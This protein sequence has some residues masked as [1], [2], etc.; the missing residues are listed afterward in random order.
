METFGNITLIHG[1]CMDYMREL[2]D[3]SID[4][5]ISDPPYGIDFCSPRTNNHD[6][7]ANDGFEE[8]QKALPLWLSEFKRVL[9][10]TGCCCCGGGG[11]KPVS[12]IFTIEIIKAGF[13]LVQTLIWDKQTIGLGWHYR[14]SY[15]TIIVFSKSKK[16]NWFDDSKKVSNIIRM[17][18]IIPQKGDHPTPKPIDLMRTLIRLHTAPGMTV[19]DPFLGGGTTALAA[20]IEHR[21]CIG[22]EL[23]HEY[24]EL[25]KQRLINHQ[26]QGKLF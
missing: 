15:E 16:Y 26:S 8:F 14:P 3:N 4:A 12:Q 11:N 13:H 17:N 21:K 2:P 7:I 22:I 1:D 24:Y 25:A 5:I 19:L 18:N 10:D 23:K 9:S 6:K 20:D